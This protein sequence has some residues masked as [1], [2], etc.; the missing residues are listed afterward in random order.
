LDLGIRKVLREGRCVVE[1]GKGKLKAY[2]N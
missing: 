2:E 1:F